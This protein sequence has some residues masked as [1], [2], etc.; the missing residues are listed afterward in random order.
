LGIGNRASGEVECGHDLVMLVSV[1]HC[2]SS[3]KPCGL[4][5]GRQCFAVHVDEASAARRP[6][7]RPEDA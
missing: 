3:G 6:R 2:C 4:P 5:G 7:S 1:P